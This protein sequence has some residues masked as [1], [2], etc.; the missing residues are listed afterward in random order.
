MKKILVVVDLVLLVVLLM[1]AA[2]AILR[3]QQ[4]SDAS[5]RASATD[6]FLHVTGGG[7][8]IVDGVC[9]LFL[10]TATPIMGHR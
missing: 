7:P 4:A 6:P 10:C 9:D 8:V 2:N 1:L 5:I 3:A